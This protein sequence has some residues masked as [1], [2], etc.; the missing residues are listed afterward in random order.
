MSIESTGKHT[1]ENDPAYDEFLIRLTAE[2]RELRETC[3]L[4]FDAM[5]APENLPE[6]DGE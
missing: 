6:Q 5:N 3:P 1:Q 2:I 4:I